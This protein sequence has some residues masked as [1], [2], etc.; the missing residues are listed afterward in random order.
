MLGGGG[1]GDGWDPRVGQLLRAHEG[2]GA[3]EYL[4][5]PANVDS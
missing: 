3:P 4:G 1:E 5:V 2:S